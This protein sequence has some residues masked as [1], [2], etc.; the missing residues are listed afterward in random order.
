LVPGVRVFFQHKLL[1]SDF[2]NK[3]LTFAKEGEASVDVHFDL[4]VGADGSYSAVRRDMMRFVKMNYEQEYITHEYVELRMP[5]RTCADGSSPSYRLDPNHLHIWPR[6]SFMLIALPNKDYTFTCTLF[7][8]AAT[9]SSL[10]TR[11]ETLSWFSTH[12]PDAVAHIGEQNLLDDFEANPKGSLICIK[13]HPYHYK[14]SVILLGDASHS[15]VPFYGQGLNCGL[16]DVRVLRNILRNDNVDPLV[17]SSGAHDAKLELALR[18]YST[19]RHDDLI[20]ICDM[21]M[22]NYVEMRH[23]VTTP[24][25]RILKAIDHFISS[26]AHPIPLSNLT[27]VLS[28]VPFPRTNPGGWLSLYTMVTFRPDIPYALARRRAQRQLGVLKIL[29]LSGVGLIAVGL[30]YSAKVVRALRRFQG[31]L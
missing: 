10:R 21:A 24:T 14:D 20:A 13:T 3:L 9:L 17:E 19:I 2:D 6:H 15:M 8:P 27:A 1:K 18:R 7:A 28:Q 30:A 12:F 16:E 26:F 11:E 4:C 22:D 29:G 25:Y 23:S 5:A 31:G